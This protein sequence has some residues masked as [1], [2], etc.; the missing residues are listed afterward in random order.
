MTMRLS[1]VPLLGATL[2]PLAPAQSWTERAL[3]PRAPYDAHVSRDFDDDGVLD[4]LLIAASAD[5][6]G[7]TGHLVSV[8]PSGGLSN[9]R[10]VI[11]GLPTVDQLVAADIDGD[12]DEDVL[13]TNVASG[14]VVFV[15]GRGDGS[16]DA[17]RTLAAIGGG[18]TN[19]RPVPRVHDRDGDGDLDI[20]F[21]GRGTVASTGLW[22]IEQITPGVFASPSLLTAPVYQILGFD[23]A[24][25]DGDG[26]GDVVASAPGTGLVFLR[27]D[28][29][30][31]LAAP[32]TIT[33]ELSDGL[34]P[35]VR[36]FDVDRNGTPD[37]VAPAESAQ[38]RVQWFA[39]DG[40]AVFSPSQNVTELLDP[41]MEIQFGDLDGDGFDDLAF[42]QSGGRCQAVLARAG[43]VF[44][45]R[46]R[47]VGGVA[48]T[49]GLDLGDVDGDGDLDAIFTGELVFPATLGPMIG[50]ASNEGSTFNGL[51][52]ETVHPICAAH[53]V[54]AALDVADVTGDGAPDALVALRTFPLHLVV[55]D[56]G[57][58]GTFERAI[59]VT[60]PFGAARDVEA[61]DLDGDG[62]ADIVVTSESQSR[63]VTY[64]SRG[65]ATWSA[66]SQVTSAVEAFEVV[67]FDLD[68]D[69]DILVSA[70]ILDNRVVRL[71]E[72]DGTG[73]FSD[74][75]RVLV[76]SSGQSAR[77]IVADDVDDDGDV[78]LFIASASSSAKSLSYFEAIGTGS[79]AGPLVLDAQTASSVRGTIA[80]AVADVTADGRRDLMA[81]IDTSTGMRVQ[82]FRQ[83][84]GTFLGGATV[85]TAPAGTV[86]NGMQVFD[87]EGDGD[88]DVVVTQIV[89]GDEPHEIVT[90]SNSGFGNFS[91]GTP[92]RASA[93]GLGMNA[94]AD[95]D[96]DGD[97]DLLTSP[98]PLYGVSPRHL[99]WFAGDST[100]TYGEPYCSEAV[101]N[102]TGEPG[103]VSVSGSPILQDDAARLRAWDTPRSAVGMFLTS[104]TRDL[105]T[106][107]PGSVGVLCLGGAIGRFTGPGQ[108]QD[109]GPTGTMSL[110][111]DLQNMPDPVL[112]PV[113]VVVGQSWNFQAWSR[114]QVTGLPTSNFTDAVTVTWQ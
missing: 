50:Y 16:F 86:A 66:P 55:H 83:L 91:A 27:D 76:L 101:A 31:G 39:N 42:E 73:A 4:V 33:S 1:I 99:T 78:D 3:F 49:V 40:S 93:R 113:T 106:N 71:F 29:G 15:R 79:F 63:F 74:A 56:N 105:V 18:A 35:D 30:P 111:L 10:P 96:L 54:P 108:V 80:L 114:D 36:A 44:S 104:R 23:V 100:T 92:F 82:R 94:F 57:G 20:Y 110:D 85:Y 45:P 34:L 26:D 41:I 19:L 22:W 75:G 109:T 46:F 72:N 43:A 17:P 98:D 97:F 9:G 7:R 11:E 95:I 8:D 60:T 88:F 90:L 5:G 67:D 69:L 52:F 103:R 2:V 47:L 70:L 84:G 89:F 62:L 12:G 48:D 32:S 6:T 59:P 87:V 61:A 58:D 25:F 68:G 112:G 28:G 13:M 64:L 53:F 21:V 14:Q 37:V 51:L 65:D 81:L 102:S 24:D 77:E 38:T 107:V